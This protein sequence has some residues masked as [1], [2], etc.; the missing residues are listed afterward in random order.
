MTALLAF[1]LFFFLFENFCQLAERRVRQHGNEVGNWNMCATGGIIRVGA[2]VG[3][4]NCIQ[5][6]QSPW[7]SVGT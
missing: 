6:D 4:R 1:Y 2:V 7:Q 3:N 5:S